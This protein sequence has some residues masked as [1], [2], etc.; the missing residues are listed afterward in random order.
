MAQSGEAPAHC[1]E[2][3]PVADS[4]GG[5][6]A[7]GMPVGQSLE[8]LAGFGAMGTPVVTFAQVTGLPLDSV[9]SA[10]GRQT[11][12]PALVVPLVFVGLVDGRR[13]TRETWV[14]APACGVAFAA[15]Q[16]AASNHVS[17]NGRR[18]YAS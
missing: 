13:G 11:P 7:H 1:Q 10:M 15:A 16:F 12:L 8:A 3:E 6:L 2:L 17:A 18:R 9:A 4:L 5:W 14:P